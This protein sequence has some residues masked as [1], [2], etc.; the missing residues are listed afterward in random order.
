MMVDTLQR[1]GDGR[2]GKP[3][4]GADHRMDQGFEENVNRTDQGFE[5]NVNR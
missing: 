2:R 5:E 1:L 3:V 4:L